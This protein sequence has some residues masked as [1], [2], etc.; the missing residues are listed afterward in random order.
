MD[1]TSDM[2][3]NDGEEDGSVRSGCEEGEGTDCEGG[4][5]DTV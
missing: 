2:L 1:G 4:N 3:W 5:I